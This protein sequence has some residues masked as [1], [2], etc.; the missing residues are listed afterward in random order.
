MAELRR[1]IRLYLLMR[2][3]A[4]RGAAQYRGNIAVM[5]LAGA[6]YQGSGF[7]FVGVLLH[8]FGTVAGWRLGEVAF[9]YGMRLLAHALW[10]VTLDGVGQ[11]D[12]AIREGHLDRMLLR[13]ANTLGQL[14]NHTR[15]LLPFGDL[16]VALVVFGVALT[17][18]DVDLSPGSVA[19]LLLAVV[20]G[21]L[22]EGSAAVLVA[23]FSVRVPDTWALRTVLF[24]AFDTLGSYPLSIF[25][26]G[27]QRV[28]TYVWPIAFVAFLPASV[29]LGR[30]GQLAVPATLGY[31][32]PAVGVVLFTLAYRFWRRQLR[33]YQGVGH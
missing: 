10:L 32:T 7:A 28:L 14:A 6:V 3:A 18:A 5:V 17:V 20:G 24:D 23:G 31:A 19:F 21:A 1:Q 8:T 15:S 11:A 16:S 26:S 9:L 13:P 27:V 30:T 33:G 2:G 25:G 29:V 12:A 4:L 22:I